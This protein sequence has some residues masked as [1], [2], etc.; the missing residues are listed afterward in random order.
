VGVT[1]PEQQG[2]PEPRKTGGVNVSRFRFWWPVCIWDC[3]RNLKNMITVKKLNEKAFY[4]SLSDLNCLDPLSFFPEPTYQQMT[5][6]IGL[7]QEVIF[8]MYKNI[9]IS[10]IEM[11]SQSYAE[12]RFKDSTLGLNFNSSGIC[13]QALLFDDSEETEEVPAFYLG[14]NDIYIN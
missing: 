2:L 10:V 7:S 11:E 1:E 6:Y 14:N 3:K 4:K 13:V 9:D 5:E 8:T 12:I